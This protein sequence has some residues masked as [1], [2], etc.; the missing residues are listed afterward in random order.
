MNAADLLRLVSAL[1]LLGLANGAPVIGKKLLGRRFAYPLDG[2]ATFFDG[3]P[4]FGP[5]K[6]VRGIVLATAATT[7]AAPLFGLAWQTGALLGASA[8]LGDLLSSFIK[9]RL[10]RPSSSQALG[11][12]QIPESL[13][14]LLVCRAALGLGGLEVAVLV[15]LFLVLELLLSR[16]LYRLHVRDRPY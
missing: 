6:T 16:L 3:R 5:S 9:R 7:L 1:L 14:P 15:V 12:D 11:L 4:L 13:L 10:G 2:G 8:M